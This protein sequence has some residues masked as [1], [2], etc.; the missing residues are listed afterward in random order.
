MEFVEG[1]SLTEIIEANIG[2]NELNEAIIAFITSKVLDGLI[3]LHNNQIIHRDIK[4]D[5]ILCGLNGDVK[6]STFFV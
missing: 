6:I 2:N 5:N 4:S 1:S 3:Y